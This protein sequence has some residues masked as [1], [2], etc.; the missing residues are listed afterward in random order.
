MDTQSFLSPERDHGEE[1]RHWA[2]FGDV[3][4]AILLVFVLFILAQF[5]QYERIFV[6]EEIDRR[7][8]V[9]AHSIDS[10]AVQWPG[11]QVSVKHEDELRQRIRISGNGELVFEPCLDQLRADGAELLHSLAGL[12]G[13]YRAYFDAVEV[14]GHADRRSPT[15]IVCVRAGIL[16]N[17]QLSAR[18]ATEVVRVFSS[19]GALPDPMLSAV[20]KGEFHPISAPFDTAQAALRHDRRIEIVLRYS[21]D[22]AAGAA[23]G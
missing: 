7:K 5:L 3:A 22:I 13:S 15:G 10:L 1:A 11:I 16:D 12:L 17:W 20:G 21:E 2:T 6:L 18:R 4:L 8:Q 14:E 9:V 23:G 19:S